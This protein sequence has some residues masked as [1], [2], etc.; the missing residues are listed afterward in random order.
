MRKSSGDTLEFWKMLQKDVRPALKDIVWAWQEEACP[1]PM[2][3]YTPQEV[4][5]AVVDHYYCLLCDGP[6]EPHK[7]YKDSSMVSRV[8]SD[9]SMTMEEIEKQVQ[10]FLG[11]QGHLMHNLPQTKVCLLWSLVA[12]PQRMTS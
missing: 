7:F 2:P 12:S 1:S 10:L 5:A 6:E 8:G 11:L 4:A 9:G 3:S